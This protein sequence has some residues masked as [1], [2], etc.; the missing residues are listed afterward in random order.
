[1][2]PAPSGW[3]ATQRGSDSPHAHQR[4]TGVSAE[5][6]LA[7]ASSWL[8]QRPVPLHVVRH[9]REGPSREAQV[10]E[11]ELAGERQEREALGAE[12]H[13]RGGQEDRQRADEQ[14]YG[15]Q[16]DI[17]DGAIGQQ[18]GGRHELDDRKDA[19]EQVLG[20]RARR[21]RC[22]CDWHQSIGHVIVGYLRGPWERLLTGSR[23][24]VLIGYE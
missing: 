20:E 12:G 13:R 19:V 22:G 15:Q 14:Q 7:R 16:P 10:L 17:A 24:G 8:G 6:R 2:R 3:Q 18:E 9:C 4:H 23:F 11:K 1:M 21:G 5:R